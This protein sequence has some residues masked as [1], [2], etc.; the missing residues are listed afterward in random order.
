MMKKTIGLALLAAA[1]AA[2][3][4]PPPVARATVAARA[5]TMFGKADT[6]RDG[7]LSRAEYRAA[8]LAVA[9]RYDPKIP[10]EGKGMDAALAQFDS[11]D[12]RHEGRIP[13]ADFIAAAL[14][15]FDGA[16]L[17]HDG[18]I[19]PDEARRAAKIKQKAILS[20]KPAAAPA[21]R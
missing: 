2:W 18:V 20:A 16:D 15:H 5:A 11:L 13:R 9:R 6:D 17:N 8:V 12:R 21:T 7:W 14:A 1:G 10:S 3:A 4:D 19:T